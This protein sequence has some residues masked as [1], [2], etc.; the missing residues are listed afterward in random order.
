MICTTA[1]ATCGSSPLTRGKPRRAVLDRYDAGLIP[2]HAGKTLP[3]GQTSWRPAAHPRSR[4][5]NLPDEI[6]TCQAGGS[7]PLT[8]G[9]LVNDAGL[10]AVGGLI[11]AHAGK[12]PTGWCRRLGAR[13]HPRSRGE[14]ADQHAERPPAWGSSPLTRGKPPRGV[15]IMRIHGL[16]PAHAGKTRFPPPTQQKPRA[17]PRSR[18]E[19][20]DDVGVDVNGPGSSPLTRGKRVEGGARD[21][22]RGLIPAHAGKTSPPPPPGEATKAH[23]RSRGE[24]LFLK[25][26]T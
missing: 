14:N 25:R 24:N 11:P 2:A 10:H 4:G 1:S 16:I 26:R 23:P 17:H 18:G 21:H 3:A 15:P 8:R 22:R 13:A 9:K 12:T 20:I 5:E 19:N 7:S 6:A